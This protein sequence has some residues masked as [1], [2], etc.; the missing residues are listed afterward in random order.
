MVQQNQKGKGGWVS[1]WSESDKIEDK[2][3]LDQDRRRQKR[4]KGRGEHGGMW[5]DMIRNI[6][7][8]QLT[9]TIRHFRSTDAINIKIYIII[10]FILSE[11]LPGNTWKFKKTSKTMLVGEG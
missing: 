1:K 3:D 9:I 5:T 8:E 7:D 2:M 11:N 4:R 6:S 10:N